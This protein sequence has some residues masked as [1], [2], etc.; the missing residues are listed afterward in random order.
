MA[1]ERKWDAVLPRSFTANGTAQGVITLN[2]TAGF[3]TKQLAYLKN[4]TIPNPLPVQVMKVLSPTKLIVG[5]INAKLSGW[6]PLDVSAWTVADGSVMGAEEQDKTANPPDGDHYKAIY[7]SDPIVADRV[8]FV[9][10]YGNFYDNNNPMPII[11][12]GT[13]AV[14]NVTIQD[15]DGDELEI[16][17]DGS[18][19]VNV[20]S[21]L[22][23]NK[24]KNTYG[25]AS[26]VPP[27]VETTI[28]TYMVPMLLSNALLQRVS[29]SGT[30]VGRYRV[31]LNGVVIDTRRTYYGG[32]F[33]EYFEFAMG[34]ADGT[35]L[36]PGDVVTVKIL[37]DRVYVGDFQGRIQALEIV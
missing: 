10:K 11:F 4:N 3:K 30:N 22:T 24:I 8:V 33:S 26:A 17:P 28:V 15:D 2:D 21:A 25:E 19:N 5:A 34:S 9:D 35:V 20:I 29:V 31:F 37:H 16:N 36:Q 23:N 6:M 7:E 12:D 27:S 13:V 1:I 18:I 32:N 14:G